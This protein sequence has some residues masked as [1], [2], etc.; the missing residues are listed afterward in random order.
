MFRRIARD[1]TDA[2]DF[3]GH[4]EQK[5]NTVGSNTEHVRD[6]CEV[7]WEGLPRRSYGL[8]KEQWDRIKDLYLAVKAMGRQCQGQSTVVEAVL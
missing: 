2:A 4:L 3:I 5:V 1:L 6:G 7:C 8:R